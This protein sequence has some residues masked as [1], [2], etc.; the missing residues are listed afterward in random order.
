[1]RIIYK[2]KSI[3]MKIQL[4]LQDDITWSDI[5]LS[6][7]W[8]WNYG[9]KYFFREKRTH[10]FSSHIFSKSYELAGVEVYLLWCIITLWNSKHFMIKRDVHRWPLSA[11]KRTCD[12][13]IAILH[14]A[15]K[16]E[17]EKQ[18]LKQKDLHAKSLYHGC[19]SVHLKQ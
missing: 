3:F 8:V 19:H 10:K 5:T 9:T 16:N 7:V 18:D 2:P 1:M 15:Q 11:N 4:H 12:P 17:R 14:K 6:S 13:S